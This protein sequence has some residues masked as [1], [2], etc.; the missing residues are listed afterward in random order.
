ME[1]KKTKRKVKKEDKNHSIP[2]GLHQSVSHF[3]KFMFVL[4]N[5]P[6]RSNPSSE[7]E[8]KESKVNKWKR[9]RRLQARCQSSLN[10]LLNDSRL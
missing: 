9:Q 2:A 8:F 10:V 3:T 6:P 4:I 7:R 1:K 5:P